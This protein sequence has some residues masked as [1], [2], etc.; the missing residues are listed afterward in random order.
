[1]AGI[2]D[3]IDRRTQLA[4]ANRL[5]L[6]LFH[7]GTKQI[8]GINVFKVKEVIQCPTLTVVP[9]SHPAVKG[10]ANMRGHTIT[11]IDLAQSIGEPSTDDLK[12]SFVVIAEYNR[13]TQ[14]Y[15][16]SGVERIVNLNWETIKPPPRG[17]GSAY[18]TA[19]TEVDGNLVEIIDIE[20]VM[21]EIIG[22]D[23]EVATEILEQK[24]E[25]GEHAVLVIDDSSVARNQIKRTLDQLNIKS[26]LSRNGKEGLK[27]LKDL[28]DAGE[29]VYERFDLIICDVEMPEMDGYTFTKEVRSDSR[30][31]KL[32]IILHTSLSGVFN[33]ALVQKVGANQ[34]LAKFNPDELGSSVLEHLRK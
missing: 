20:K 1:M 9:H 16:V 14:G 24:K 34:F 23:E 18:M 13:T 31:D 10:V 25:E 12:N 8:F 7:L 28:A 15:L 22:V 4:G 30:L 2:L 29:N 33:Q 17:A 6:L 26:V 21:S 11:V 19:V 27:I 32:Y 3:D 5:E